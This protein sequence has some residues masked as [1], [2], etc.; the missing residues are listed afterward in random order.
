MFI[1]HIQQ[2]VW[3]A[4]S[5]ND[6]GASSWSAD[7][8]T[9]RPPY[10]FSIPNAVRDAARTGLWMRYN[11][12]GGGTDTG[13]A[14]GKQLASRKK[15]DARSLADMRTWFAR[16]GPDA[17]NKGTSYRGY[18]KWVG[19]GKPMSPSQN[20][21]ANHFRGAVAWLLWGGDPAY[22]WLKKSTGVRKSLN[23][24]FSHRK[25]SSKTINLTC[26]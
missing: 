23:H 14:R 5:K 22:R 7:M 6:P 11:G 13:Y 20:Y 3:G 21:P 16:H 4:K 24:Y 9:P 2:L 1:R 25:R 26:G 12:F 15:I 17:F 8:T 10:Y 18:C 19:L